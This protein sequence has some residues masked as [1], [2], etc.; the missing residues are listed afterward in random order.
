MQISSAIE[1][2][3]IVRKVRKKLNLT[4]TKLAAACGSGTRFIVDLEHGKSTCEIGKALRVAQM[5]GMRIE[6]TEFPF[7]S[8]ELDK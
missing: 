1:L 6:I 5:L 8:E 3:Q 7:P 2:G 4:Q